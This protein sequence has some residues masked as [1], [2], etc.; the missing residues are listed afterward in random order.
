M[1]P[2]CRLFCVFF[3]VLLLTACGSGGKTYR[4]G[5]DP[6]W[7]PV[8]MQGKEANVYAFANELLAAI[9]KEEGVY[10]ER[11]TTSWDNL[12]FGLKQGHYEGMLSSMTPRVFLERTYTFSD[13]FLSIGPVLVVNNNTKVSSL[14]QMKGKEIAVDSLSSEAVLIDRFPG[15]I[16]QYYTSIPQGLNDTIEGYYDGVLLNYLQ[17]TSYV[18][19]L[20][21]GKVKI[22]TPPLDDT[23][24]RLLTLNGEN[25]HL[26]DVFNRGLEKLRDKGKLDKLLK[27][28]EIN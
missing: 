7:Y 13:S 12:I 5:I 28:W 11:V 2:L 6:S 22:A 18:R 24:L 23:G 26:V 1:K 17:A 25:E 3:L 27:K 4:V 10:F 20:Y 21:Y 9:G 14:D 16:V 8:N 15:V 19:D